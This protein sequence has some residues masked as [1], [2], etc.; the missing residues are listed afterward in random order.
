MFPL[1][2]SDGGT[3]ALTV[4]NRFDEIRLRAHVGRLEPSREPSMRV[5]SSMAWFV[6]P[7]QAGQLLTSSPNTAFGDN[8]A[9]D[10]DD[11]RTAGVGFIDVKSFFGECAHETA[12]RLML[13]AGAPAGA[14]A[15]IVEALRTIFPGGRGLPIGFEGSGPIAN[16]FLARLDEELAAGDSGSCDQPSDVETC[17]SRAWPSGQPYTTS[18]ARPRGG[19]ASVQ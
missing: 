8:C 9:G 15:V 16:L 17:S 18:W 12:E 2:K 7:G 11:D 6:D 3:R 10:A 1:P 14:V 19:R 13:G 4:L 5:T